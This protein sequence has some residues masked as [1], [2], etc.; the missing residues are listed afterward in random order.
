[1]VA[2]NGN[3]SRCHSRTN[4]RSC[5]CI[6]ARRRRKAGRQ[7]YYGTGWLARNGQ[8]GNNAQPYYNNGNNNNNQ[9]SQPAPP[10]SQQ[11]QQNYNGGYY[12]NQ[13]GQQQGVE[14]QSPQA[15]YNP[16]GG[17]H[18]FTPPPGPPPGKV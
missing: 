8:Y 14:L 6:T 12:G 9:Y 18:T 2:A 10:Y 15:A 7:P 11:P 5:R 3:A 4:T 1:M 17:D 13:Y 16:T